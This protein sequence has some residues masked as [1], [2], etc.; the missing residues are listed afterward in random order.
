LSLLW[1]S[2]D[3]G[4]GKSVLARSLIHEDLKATES[5]VVC[6]FFFKDDNDEQKSSTTALSALLHQLFSQK[7]SLIKYALSDYGKESKK[8]PQLFY[9]LWNILTN[10]ASDPEAGEVICVLDALDECEESGRYNI[11]TAL[12]TLYKK[13]SCSKRT[14]PKL[15]FLVTSRPYLDIERKFTELTQDLPTIRLQ[16]EQES[17]A[18]RREIDLVIKWRVSRFGSEL[19]LNDLERSTLEKELLSMTHRTYLWL[20]LIFDILRRTVRPTKNKLK[21]IIGTLPP[22]VDKAYEAILSKIKEDERPQARKLL[23]IIIAAARPFTL[24]TEA[25]KGLTATHM[26]GGTSHVAHKL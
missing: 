7:Q 8:L 2:A 3:P 13:I 24:N 26:A 19:Q 4:C 22:T 6:H 20:K 16:G 17:E 23:H 9:K 18:I 5:R 14:L 11:I 1:V 25:C 21:T 10:S 12:N 15:K